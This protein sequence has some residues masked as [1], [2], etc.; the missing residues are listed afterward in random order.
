MKVSLVIQSVLNQA[1]RK[2]TGAAYA[3][4]F[5]VSSACSFDE[6]DQT[7]TDSMQLDT[8]TSVE[9]LRAASCT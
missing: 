5:P 4:N 1:D 3:F 7:G 8:A 2:D 9:A 6:S